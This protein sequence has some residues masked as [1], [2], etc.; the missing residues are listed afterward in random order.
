MNDPVR[1]AADD[2][3]RIIVQRIVGAINRKPCRAH[4]FGATYFHDIETPR[5][6]VSTLDNRAD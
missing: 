2:A 5:P 4:A 6:G 1:D 3:A